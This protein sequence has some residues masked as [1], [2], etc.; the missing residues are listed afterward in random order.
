MTARKITVNQN[1]MLRDM[2]LMREAD[3]C[4]ICGITPKTAESW[5]KHHKGP[6]AVRMGN[7][8]FYPMSWVKDHVLK[9]GSEKLQATTQI[10]EVFL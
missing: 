9:L 3:L 1:F 4:Q 5:R 2:G 6:I 8:F 10:G 7:E